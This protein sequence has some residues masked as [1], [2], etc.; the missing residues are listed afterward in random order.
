MV[1]WRRTIYR[2]EGQTS[3]EERSV[4]DRTLWR[5]RPTP[6]RPLRRSALQL[7]PAPWAVTHD[8][9]AGVSTPGTLARLWSVAVCEGEVPMTFLHASRTQR[10]V[11]ASVALVVAILLIASC[12]DGTGATTTTGA[13]TAAPTT[14]VQPPTT[15]APTT[16]SFVTTTSTTRA[17]ANE[18]PSITVAGWTTIYSQDGDLHI[19]GWLDRP[20]EVMVGDVRAETHPDVYA[21]ATTFAADLELDAGEHAIEVTAVDDAGLENSIF[22][23]VLVDPELEVEL[24]YLEEVDFV[25]RT[26]LVND[27]QFLSGDEA[28][29]AAVE[30]GIIAEGEDLPNDFYIRDQNLQPRTLTLGDPGVIVLL[31]CFPHPGPCVTRQ[32]VA[33]DMWSELLDD[34]EVAPGKLGWHWY[35]YAELPYWFTIQDGIVVQIHEQYLP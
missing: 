15:A 1:A 9:R 28:K 6:L 32:A 26:L 13:A 19:E 16:T 33:V 10:P 30:D 20:A 29:Q 8:G 34:P 18:P 24:G 22:L 31:A 7:A 23:S 35:G 12:G 27:V 5:P 2:D 25:A 11:A 14:T 21:D 3:I 17:P 4:D